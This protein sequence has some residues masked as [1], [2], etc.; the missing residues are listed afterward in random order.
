LQETKEEES[1]INDTRYDMVNEVETG[2]PMCPGGTFLSAMTT[3]QEIGIDYPVGAGSLFLGGVLLSK[4]LV[5]R[6]TCGTP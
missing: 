5:Y 1:A 3:V 2:Y 4:E 6:V